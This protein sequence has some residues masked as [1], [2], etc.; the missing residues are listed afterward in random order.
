[1]CWLDDLALPEA[2][3]KASVPP[4]AR[5]AVEAWHLMGGRI[6]WAALEPIAEMLGIRDIETL[7]LQLVTIR[8]R[9]TSE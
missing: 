6:D 9:E 8:D 3:R 1:M 5:L 7:V 4:S 2:I